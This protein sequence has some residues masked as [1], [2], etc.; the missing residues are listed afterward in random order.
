MTPFSNF[1]SL[2]SL[3]SVCLLFGGSTV[4]CRN[5]GVC[6]C[7]VHVGYN[8][9]SISGEGSLQRQYHMSTD[10]RSIYLK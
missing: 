5:V 8:T 7:W 9:G 10:S 6:V 1:G 3:V 2:Y 4:L